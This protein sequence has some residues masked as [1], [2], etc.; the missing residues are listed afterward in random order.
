MGN[1]VISGNKAL[2]EAM[3]DNNSNPNK[4]SAS[5]SGNDGTIEGIFNNALSIPILKNSIIWNNSG[6]TN[7]FSLI[8]GLL[9]YASSDIFIKTQIQV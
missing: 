5:I 8:E 4:F 6:A 2:N 3:Y 9:N 7:S 1:S